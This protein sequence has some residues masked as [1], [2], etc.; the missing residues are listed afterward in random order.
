VDVAENK[1]VKGSRKDAF[2]SRLTIT[3][4]SD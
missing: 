4:T 1:E 2:D 3:I